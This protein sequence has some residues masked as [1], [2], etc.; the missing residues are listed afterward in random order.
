MYLFVRILISILAGVLFSS[1]GMA[2]LMPA[3]MAWDSGDPTGPMKI[4]SYLSFTIIPVSLIA[5]V[6]SCS[7]G[8]GFLVLNLLPVFGILLTFLYAKIIG[9]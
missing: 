7:F 2:L 6:L 8:Y 4:I 5:T 9:E 3:L 1:L